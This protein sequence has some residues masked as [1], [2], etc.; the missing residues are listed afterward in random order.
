[1]EIKEIQCSKPLTTDAKYLAATEANRE[2]CFIRNL[3]EWLQVDFD[4]PVR[5]SLCT[6]TTQMLTP[7]EQYLRRYCNYQ[8]DNWTELLTMT[9]FSY[10]NTLSSST[11]ITP[12][13]AIYGEH[14][15]YLIQ[16]RP[17][18]LPPPVTLR[19]FADNLAS[20]N[21]YLR[22]EMAWAQATFAE[23]ADKHRIPAP[24]F[25]VGNEV[26]LLPKNLKTT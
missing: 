3:F 12:F 17:I 7:V 26:W 25:E 20:L 9:E 23:Q 11:R 19:E 22:S 16:L 4:L 2:L 15:R 1:M 5:E 8:P 13:Y 21:G 18:T 10:I 24:K 6:E 14:P